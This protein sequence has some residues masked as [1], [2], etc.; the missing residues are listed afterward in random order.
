MLAEHIKKSVAT[1]VKD[2]GITRSLIKVEDADGKS[3][4]V[5]GAWTSWRGYLFSLS[6]YE[7]P[8]TARYPATRRASKFLKSTYSI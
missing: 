4:L 5:T 7:Q 3:I 8:F 2:I 1:F 6:K